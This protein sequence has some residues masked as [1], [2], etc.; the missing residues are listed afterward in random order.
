MINFHFLSFLISIFSFW[1][2]WPHHISTKQSRNQTKN[3]AYTFFCIEFLYPQALLKSS[4]L[5]MNICL[6]VSLSLSLSN[7]QP[8]SLTLPLAIFYNKSFFLLDIGIKKSLFWTKNSAGLVVGC[9]CVTTCKTV[10]QFVEWNEIYK[11]PH[12]FFLH[13]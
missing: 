13:S 5:S 7:S 10:C 9:F 3:S 6:H 4:G 1:F 8:N 2:F 12:D 11:K